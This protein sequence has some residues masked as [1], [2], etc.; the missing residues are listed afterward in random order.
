[1]RYSHSHSHSHQ[2]VRLRGWKWIVH[3]GGGSFDKFATLPRKS[4]TSYNSVIYVRI[5]PFLVPRL[6]QSNGRKETTKQRGEWQVETDIHMPLHQGEETTGLSNKVTREIEKLRKL[7][8]EATERRNEVTQRNDNT[9]RRVEHF[10][11]PRFD[12]IVKF[13]QMA[14]PCTS[15]PTI[16]LAQVSPRKS[17]TLPTYKCIQYFSQKVQFSFSFSFFFSQEKKGYFRNGCKEMSW[18]KE[19]KKRERILLTLD[20]FSILEMGVRTGQL[21]PITTIISYTFPHSLR[22]ITRLS[23]F[24]F[25]GKKNTALFNLVGQPHV[26]SMM[27]R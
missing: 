24:L 19:I 20:E 9:K 12:F 25:L 26:V 17:E 10:V 5:T 15:Y 14:L 13:V 4:T 22:K 11:R 2:P 1:M 18:K 23:F 8:E 16:N 7:V 27:C 21:I 6:A 3:S